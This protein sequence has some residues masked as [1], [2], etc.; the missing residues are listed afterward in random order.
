MSFPSRVSLCMIVRNEE[1]FLPDCLASVRPVVDEMIVL[2]TGSTDRSAELAASAGARVLH[3]PWQEDF[4]AARNRSIGAAT[5]DWILVL[6]ADERLPASSA[7]LLREVL[8]V[9]EVVAYLVQ[10]RN[11]THGGEAMGMTHTAWLPRLFRNHLGVHYTGAVHECVLPSLRNKESVRYSP[12]VIDHLGYMR[13]PAAMREKG[14]RNLTILRRE[15]QRAPQDA[16]L[17]I[18]LA[19]T[20]TVLGRIDEAIED[21]RMALK[22]A[23]RPST[24]GEA[25]LPPATMALAAQ[26]LGAALLI[27]HQPLEAIIALQDAL[28]RWPKL[29][30]AHVYLGQAYAQL[31]ESE[32]ALSHLDQAIALADAPPSPEHPVRLVPWFAWFLK[33]SL[34]A[35]LG[36]DGKAEKSLLSSL[37]LKP[38]L[39]DAH[40]LLGIIRLMGG[41]SR[42]A[43]EALEAARALGS[44]S[45]TLLVNLAIARRQI[46]DLPGAR[47]VLRE[48]R[49]ADP[50]DARAREQFEEVKR[51]LDGA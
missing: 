44:P 24:Q 10:M 46:G 9:P 36:R 38:D 30:S 21:Y 16:P 17:W 22:L 26:Q 2:D 39:R 45:V 23:A 35:A 18:Q 3:A 5:G 42:S 20:C 6:D 32:R 48:A 11:P 40:E 4:A 50:S 8:P 41:R 13:G 37:S 27:R 43:L 1:T 31:G 19:E 47:D 25:I 51:L 34:E 28:A 14:L 15:S 12:I 49:E 33:G 29:A 7:P